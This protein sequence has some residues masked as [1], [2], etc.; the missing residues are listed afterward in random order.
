MRNAPPIE[1]KAYGTVA[2]FPGPGALL[3]AVS[4]LRAAGLTKLDTHTPFPV[5]GMDKA[6]GLKQSR[7]PWFTLVGALT[8]T[9]AAGTMQWWMNAVDYKI[10]IGGKPLVSYHAYVPVMFEVTVLL[11]AITTVLTLLAL[12]RLPRPHHALF[13][14]PRFHKAT[15]DGFFLSVEATDPRWDLWHTPTLLQEAGGNH[16]TTVYE[17]GGVV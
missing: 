7:L 3:H 11:G 9:I 6:L 2:E 12:T 1:R 8:G 15:D 14:H 16:V 13:S 10:R 4:A 5:H 17:E